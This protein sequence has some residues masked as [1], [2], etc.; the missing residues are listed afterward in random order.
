MFRYEAPYFQDLSLAFLHAVGFSA[1][2]ASSYVWFKFLPAL[3]FW[4]KVSKVGSP[5][6]KHKRFVAS[7]ALINS[8][9]VI[10]SELLLTFILPSVY[11]GDA[12]TR[13]LLDDVAIYAKIIFA[14]LC[15]GFMNYYV[16]TARR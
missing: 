13:A 4:A 5:V 7:V 16:L 6:F 3:S 2:W 9:A 10:V 8:G 15:T 11:F 14:F 1:Y 12:E